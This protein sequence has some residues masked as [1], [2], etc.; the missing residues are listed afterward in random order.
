MTHFNGPDYNPER[1]Q[2]RLAAQMAAIRGLMR[3]GQWR[4]LGDIA[5]KCGAPEA[6]VSA[7]LRH[8]RKERFG[9]HIVNK[10]HVSRG[11][12]EYQLIENKDPATP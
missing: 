10:R 8:L 6:S 7:Q 12:F 5:A 1:D 4:T 3:D 11:L 2:A 9:S